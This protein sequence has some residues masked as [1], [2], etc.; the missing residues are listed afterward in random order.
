MGASRDSTWRAKRVRAAQAR[1]SRTSAGRACAVL[2]AVAALVLPASALGTTTAT[3]TLVEVHGH[4]LDGT[5]VGR[6]YA[7]DTGDHDRPLTDEHQPSSLVGQRVRLADHDAAPGLQG[8]VSAADDQ[9]LVA[10]P[11]A[12]ARSLLV[13]LLTMPDAPQPSATADAARTAVFTGA[14]SADAFYEQQSAGATRF[15]GRLRSDGDV[16][17]PLQIP[18]TASGCNYWAIANAADA[19]ARSAGWDPSAYDHIL[20]AL[21]WIRS[22]D[23][24]GLGDLPGR[25]SWINGT[26]HTNLVAHELGHNLG[27]HH[28]NAYRCTDGDEA[29]PLSSDCTSTEYRDPFDVMGV[30]SVLMSSWHRAQIGQLPAAEQVTVRQSQTLTLVSSDDVTSSGPRSLLVP[31]KEPDGGVTSWISLELRSSRPPFDVW[32]LGAPVTTGISARIVPDLTT[33]AQTQLLDAHPATSTSLDAALQPGESLR[34]GAHGI[35]ITAGAIGGGTATVTVTMPAAGGDLAPSAPP[36]LASSGDSNGVTL[37]WSAATDD[38]AIDHYDVERDGS[39]LGSTRDLSFSDVRVAELAAPVY[40]VIA[41]DR[42]GNRRASA[43]LRVYPRDAT[44]PSTVPQL[45]ATASDAG[46]VLSWSPAQD[47]RAVR[48]YRIERDGVT[49]AQTSQTTIV[50]RPGAGRHRYEAS[51]EDPAGNRGAPAVANAAVA[52]TATAAAAPPPRTVLSRSSWTGR[53]VTMR[54]QAVGATAMRASSAGRQLVRSTGTRLTVRLRLPARAT[55][56]TIRVVASSPAG[57]STHSW[58]VVATTRR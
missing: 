47:N 51:A 4:R 23:W 26:L 44:P 27:A 25:H 13:I 1:G 19:A 41:V 12:G 11:G 39:I 46:V 43:P 53:T 54:F 40:R 14:A 5:E 33:I 16:A 17:G 18:V 28:A 9:R 31:R 49:V 58:T 35:T 10:A 36:N 48:G 29:V 38:D 8:R 34:D 6:S 57:S 42:G 32:T 50:D 21:P 55:R 7:I 30:D 45:N 20:Y 3:G 52:A 22:C 2:S 56:R 15:G 24:G 37:T